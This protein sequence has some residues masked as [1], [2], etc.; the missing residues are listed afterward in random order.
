MRYVDKAYGHDLGLSC[1]F[2]Q[3][4]AQSHC[5][6]LH[7]YALAVRL[8]FGA[9]SLDENGWVIDFGGLRP[10][11]Q[12]LCDTFD[13]KMLVAEDDPERQTLVA[14]GQLT[15]NFDPLADVIVL[16]KVGCE[17]FADYIFANVSSW[18]RRQRFKNDVRLCEVEV[19][20]HSGNGAISNEDAY[21]TLDL[22]K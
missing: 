17:A 2:R 16:P 7:G 19:R 4:R 22:I 21:G 18:V 12:W 13:H 15:E 6:L 14:L 3:W 20:E 10:V 1:V 9:R 8:R 11:K 5:R